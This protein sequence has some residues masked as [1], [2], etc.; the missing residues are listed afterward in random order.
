MATN[1][2]APGMKL[3]ALIRNITAQSEAAN[4]ANE[5]FV[6][7]L[8]KMA[9]ELGEYEQ[10]LADKKAAG[11]R[12]LAELEEKIAAKLQLHKNVEA[13][14]KTLADRKAVILRQ[15]EEATASKAA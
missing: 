5:A 2:H 1:K 14:L 9:D 6:A 3:H 8:T 4:T 10:A 12:E 7:M 15:L 11:Q 13:S